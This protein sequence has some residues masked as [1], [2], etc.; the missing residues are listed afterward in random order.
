MS[1]LS[2]IPKS[3]Q[4]LQFYSYFDGKF[5]D[6]SYKTLHCGLPILDENDEILP[7][8]LE[9]ES[10]NFSRNGCC[11]QIDILPPK[12]KYLDCSNN[13]IERLDAL[14]ASL[15]F[16]NCSHNPYIEQLD[17]LPQNLKYLNCTNN[18]I[19]YLDFLPYNLLFLYCG[20]NKIKHLYNL[21]PNLLLLDTTNYSNYGNIALDPE[22]NKRI[23][24]VNTPTTQ[25][26]VSLTNN[27][28]YNW[29]TGKILFY[30]DY[31]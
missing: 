25:I 22:A 9:L 18:N 20:G 16:L 17:N 14:P 13:S 15:E 19:R 8:Y 28:I 7:D 31:L 3:K 30:L 6:C 26:N 24:Y 4:E 2:T 11:A 1:K 23:K 21:P 5:L 29:K 10:I 12:L 27:V